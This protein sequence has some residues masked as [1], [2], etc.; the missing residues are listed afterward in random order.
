MIFFGGLTSAP[1]AEV[2]KLVSPWVSSVVPALPV[3]DAGSSEVTDCNSDW[4]M[5]M[6][7]YGVNGVPLAHLA[8]GGGQGR[9]C[10]GSSGKHLPLLD[11]AVSTSNHGFPGTVVGQ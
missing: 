3:E 11:S 8:T 6:S 4:R 5:C 1:L 9:S 2:S 10:W 7:G